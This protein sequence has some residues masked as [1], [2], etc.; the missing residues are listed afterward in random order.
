VALQYLEN[1]LEWLDNVARRG[2]QNL[3][4]DMPNNIPGRR[5]MRLFVQEAKL[6][7]QEEE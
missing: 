3:L 5:A 7:I 2:E 4:D 1:C 6:Q